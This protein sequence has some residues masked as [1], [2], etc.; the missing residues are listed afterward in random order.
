M[1]NLIFCTYLYV[2]VCVSVCVSVSVS[3]R[4]RVCTRALVAHCSFFAVHSCDRILKSSDVRNLGES[5]RTE[6]EFLI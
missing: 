4:V 5:I 6:S 3:V 2:C 1:W